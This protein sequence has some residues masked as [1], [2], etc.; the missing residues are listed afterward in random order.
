MAYNTLG[1]TPGHNGSIT[2]VSDGKLIF[3]LE[4]ERL[5]KQKY[6]AEPYRTLTYVLNRYHV[7]EFILAGT[8][9]EAFP[10]SYFNNKDP[11][12]TYQILAKKF[13]PKSKFTILAHLHH[14]MHAANAFYSSGFKEAA[15]IVIDA[16]G[17]TISF[18]FPFFKREI[19]GE[20]SESIYE[21]SY[22][23]TFNSIQKNYYSHLDRIY[24]PKLYIDNS[25]NVTKAYEVVTQHLGFL[26][27]EAGKTMGLSSYGNPNNNLPKFFKNKRGDRSIFNTQLEYGGYIDSIAHPEF[28]LFDKKSW[29]KDSSKANSLVKDMAYNM[30]LESQEIIGDLVEE[31]I[32]KT[33]QKNI[34]ITGGY[35]LN[36]VT[37]Y[38]MVKRFPN[39]NFYH[40]PL[41][42]DAGTSIG[43][44]LYG[45]YKHT[46]SSTIHPIK[47]LYNGPKYSQEELLEGIKK[48]V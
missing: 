12:N 23:F 47:T 48:Y 30:Q 28:I 6:D 46:K 15:V 20:E 37:N 42:S 9:I 17:S 4:E 39:I 25:M 31:A 35:G 26:S 27:L 8:S 24:E 10:L 43:A 34:C 41:S 5:S 40:D 14:Q 1:I 33:K 3:H 22:P 11:Q 7:D 18:D 19:I 29:H 45:W 21:S 44:A 32:Q 13:F 36:C 38:Y 2:L 16:T